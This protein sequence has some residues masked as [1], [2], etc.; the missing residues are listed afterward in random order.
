M[1][2]MNKHNWHVLSADQTLEQ[3][4][5]SDSGLNDREVRKRKQK[6]GKNELPKIKSKTL[7][8]IILSQFAN[9]LIYI[10]VAAAI[11]TFILKEY[12]DSMF[13]LIVVALNTIVGAWQEYKAENSAAALR[14]MVKDKARVKRNGKVISVNSEELVPGDIVLLESGVKVPADI[15]LL[16]VNGLIAEEALLTG[17][18]QPIGKTVEPIK[19]ENAAVGDR[20]NMAFAAT[21]VLKGRATGLVVTT[22]IKTEMGKIAESLATS[23]AQ[24][25][26][27]VKRMEVFSKKI[28]L[29]VLFICILLGVIAYLKDMELL[30]VFMLAVAVGVSA[31]PEGLPIALTVA[32][33]VGT[34]RMAKRNVIVRKLPAVEGLGSCTMIASDKTGTLTMDQQSLR[35]ILLPDGTEISVTGQGYNGE[36][37]L[38]DADGGQITDPDDSLKA[39][40]QAAALANEANLEKQGEQWEYSGDVIDV[41]FLAVSY[42][43]GTTPDELRKQV[44]ITK[45]LPYESEKK[46]SGVYFREDEKNWFAIKGAYEV[47]IPY[48][49]KEEQA[50]T[51]EH[52]EKLAADGYRVLLL[53]K[54]AA[55]NADKKEIPQLEIIG[56]AGFI[57]PLR[58][59]VVDAIDECHRAGISVKMIT[60]DHPATALAIARE[61]HIAKSEEDV[62]TGP[63]LKELEQKS[64]K[65]AGSV[66]RQK[67]VFARVTPLQKKLIVEAAKEDG[68]FVAVTGDGA[69]DA[70]AMKVAHIS[71]AMGSGT[72]LTKET[73]SII[74]TDDNFASIATGVRVGRYTYDNLRKVVYLLISTGIAELLAIIVALL[75]NLPLPFIAVQ[76]LWLNLVTNGIQDIALAFEKGDPDTMKNPPRSPRES[77]FDKRMLQQMMISGLVIAVVTLAFWY[78]LIEVQGV[79]QKLARTEILMLMVLFQNFHVLN[80]RSE[81]RSILRIP[82][83]NNW[84]LIM[85]I[86]VAQGLHIAASYIPGL[87]DV[88]QVEPIPVGEWAELLILASSI[89]VVMEIYKIFLRRSLKQRETP[90]VH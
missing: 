39:F 8:Q 57:D 31:I 66:L 35:K 69:N 27:L 23:V 72:D 78:H 58:P 29:V 38:Q 6:Y 45:M 43:A 84:I 59:E 74:V 77:I 40:L 48:L 11:V 3:L 37:E 12:S 44:E 63:Q 42:K 7:L 33:S 75:I 67:T 26:P 61:L 14:N 80:C 54:G 2:I 56:L 60:G 41:A 68:D 13:I 32:L 47:I 19:E 62:M 25:P 1:S 34:N 52:A 55:G 90:E 20:T 28:S 17:E 76:L 70:P 64:T 71:I 16:E 21:S 88:L 46:Y 82:L 86:A 53:A 79:N 15:R 65:E 5:V 85:A 24:K 18:S 36:G 51:E 10:L 9:P 50:F 4:S 22:G 49:A 30:E 83:K 81:T 87:S 73:A 89:L